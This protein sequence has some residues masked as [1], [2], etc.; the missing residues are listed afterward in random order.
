MSYPSSMF[1]KAKLVAQPLRILFDCL[2]LKRYQRLLYIHFSPSLQ[3]HPQL[4]VFLPMVQS[5]EHRYLHKDC[6]L[7]DIFHSFNWRITWCAILLS[8]KIFTSYFAH[9]DTPHVI[10]TSYCIFLWYLYFVTPCPLFSAW[11]L[12]FFVVVVV[13]IHFNR[14]QMKVI[15]IIYTMNMRLILK[16]WDFIIKE[17]LLQSM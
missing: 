10:R 9:P 6:I 8:S 2:H 5:A 4:D 16:L 3:G 17:G 14:T 11:L 13:V 12:L 7:L 1:S 15:V